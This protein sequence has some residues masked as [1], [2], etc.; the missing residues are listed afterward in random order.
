[1]HYSI[2]LQGVELFTCT[3]SGRNSQRYVHTQGVCNIILSTLS[4]NFLI[5]A[6]SLLYTRSSFSHS[7]FKQRTVRCVHSY[8][9]VLSTC[10]VYCVWL[11]WASGGGARI[12]WS[13]VDQYLP[14]VREA[15]MTYCVS[16]STGPCFHKVRDCTLQS[17]GLCVHVCAWT[18]YCDSYQ[19]YSAT[20]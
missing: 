3:C 4:I 8:L 12:S 20:S 1:M 16:S 17:T 13:L 6:C 2:D 9:P 14:G 15:A 7:S 18:A 11:V 10:S 19:M 5:Y